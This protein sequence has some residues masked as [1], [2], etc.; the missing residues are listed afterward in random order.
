MAYGY[1]LGLVPASAY[2]F[3]K[4]LTCMCSAGNLNKS[5]EPVGVS[6]QACLCHGACQSLRESQIAADAASQVQLL[7]IFF[8][9]S[10]THTDEQVHSTSETSN[11]YKLKITLLLLIID[12]S[13]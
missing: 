13:P 6:H 9:P 5:P 1:E 12:V 4:S 7:Q 2:Q 8:F 11:M 3:V 10:S